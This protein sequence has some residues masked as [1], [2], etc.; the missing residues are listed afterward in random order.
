MTKTELNKY[1]DLKKEA[2]YIENKIN[3]LKEKKTSIKSFILK[4]GGMTMLRKRELQFGWTKQ[5]SLI[6]VRPQKKI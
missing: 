1:L 2:K 5:N 4:K 6:S 3:E